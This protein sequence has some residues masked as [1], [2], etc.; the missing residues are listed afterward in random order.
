MAGNLSGG[1]SERPKRTRETLDALNQLD[2]ARVKLKGLSVI[3]CKIA[4]GASDN[5]EVSMFDGLSFLVD[6]IDEDI[7]KAYELL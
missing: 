7:S 5:D 1:V 2:I 6:G 4:C 3:L